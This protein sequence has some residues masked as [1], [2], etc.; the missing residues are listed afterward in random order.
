MTTETSQTPTT[1]VESSAT[2]S[3][4]I[5]VT[6]EERFLGP[7]K[8]LPIYNPI[9]LW[10]WIKYIILQ[11]VTRDCISHDDE[12]VK[13]ALDKAIHYDT[14]VEYLWTF[15]QVASCM[16]MSI[17]HGTIYACHPSL[18]SAMSSC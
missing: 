16:I 17:A 14:E 6:A 11:G 1:T 10:S 9:R 5:L 2:A 15:A 12:S 13:N 3:Q 18:S 4:A 7:T 8:D